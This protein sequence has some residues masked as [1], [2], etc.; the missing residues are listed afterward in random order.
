[1]WKKVLAFIMGWISTVMI[2]SVTEASQANRWGHQHSVAHEAWVGAQWGAV[3]AT[4][5]VFFV[6]T[7]MV[8]VDLSLP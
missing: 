3:W 2:C 6:L 4:L 8:I 1:M 7:V 5:G